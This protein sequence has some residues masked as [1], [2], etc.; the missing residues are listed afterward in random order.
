MVDEGNV[1]HREQTQEVPSGGEEATDQKRKTGPRNREKSP[2]QRGRDSERE[3]ERERARERRSEEDGAMES[4]HEPENEGRGRVSE[5]QRT[6]RVGTQD[7]R[8]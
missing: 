7:D 6:D 5:E 1:V 4:T 3:S 2:R 8:K